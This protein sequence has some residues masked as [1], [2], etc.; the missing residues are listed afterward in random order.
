FAIEPRSSTEMLLGNRLRYEKSGMPPL[1]M[2]VQVRSNRGEVSVPSEVQIVKRATLD[3]A[4]NAGVTPTL[5]L[6]TN[7]ITLDAGIQFTMR[8]D[9]VVPVEINQRL[10]RQYLYLSTSAFGNWLAVRGSAFHESGPFSLRQLNS[11]ETGANVEFTVARPWGRMGLVTGWS[12]R[13]LKFEPLVREFYTT[14]TYAGVERRFGKN[15]KLTLLGNYIRSWRVQ[16]LSYATAQAMTPSFA[17]DYRPS[18]KWTFE[19]NFAFQRGMNIHTYDNVQSR[20]LISYIKP[21]RSN[22]SDGFGVVPVEYPIRISFGVQQAQFM[23]FTG[24]GS[25]QIRPVVRV[26]LF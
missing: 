22:T 5:S 24:R 4:F 11:K 23:N 12:A 9:S 6:G 21:Y 10:F 16:D 18:P 1:T 25:S 20:I 13:N 17:F 3:T 26:S 8:R 15:L 19:G 2:G 14:N 7:R